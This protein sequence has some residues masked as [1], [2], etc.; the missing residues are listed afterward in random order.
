MTPAQKCCYLYYTLIFPA[1]V[2]GKPSRSSVDDGDGKLRF[3]EE[4]AQSLTAAALRRALS[5]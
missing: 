1:A 5:L 3:R 4:L 2:Q